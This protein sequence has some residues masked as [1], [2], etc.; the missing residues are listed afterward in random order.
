MYG[1]VKNVNLDNVKISAN[2]DA[3]GG[4][5]GYLADGASIENCNI[6]NLDLTCNLQPGVN[7]AEGYKPE[8]A[9][10][11]G[12]VGLNNGNISGTSVSGTINIPNAD[13]SFGY[14]GGA[15]GANINTA[16]GES[17]IENTY[18]DVDIVL[19]NK[20]DYS[21]SINGFIGDDSHETTIKNCTSMGSITTA[22]GAPINGTDLANWGPVIESDVTNMIALDTRNNN[23]VL[24]WSNSTSPSFDSGSENSSSISNQTIQLP[25]GTT[26]NVFLKPGD[27]GYDEQ[28]ANQATA[29]ANGIPAINLT[30]IQ[31]ATLVQE[32]EK[33]I[34]DTTQPPIGYEQKAITEEVPI[35]ELRYTEDPDFDGISSM[36]LEMGLR[37]GKYQLITPANSQTTQT[38]NL[39]GTDFELVSVSSCTLITD[40]RDEQAVALAEAEY[41]KDMKK[42]QTKDKRYEMDQ[43]KID[44]QYNALLAEEESVKTAINKNVERSF[45]TFG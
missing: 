39:N 14:I 33:E 4:M 3:I 37:S 41:E 6:T 20:T 22:G 16:K 36:E 11:G 32:N 42:I 2:T 44:T 23:N 38:L 30:A 31:A 26:A 7:Y 17:V 43:K 1:T 8:R 19:S 9:G 28:A 25:D 29:T 15:I 13:E 34:P 27:E 21:N 24:Y 45:K 18:A 40:M 5:A 12:I 10:V 35:K